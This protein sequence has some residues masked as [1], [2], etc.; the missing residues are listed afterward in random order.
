MFMQDDFYQAE[1]DVVAMVMTQLYL[2]AGHKTWGDS[3][4]ADAHSE[5]KQLHWRNTFKS[6]HLR[7]L[8]HSQRQMVLESHMFLKEKRDEKMKAR[9]VAGGNKQRGYISKDDVDSTTTVDIQSVLLTCIIDAQ[10][11]RGVAVI[12]VPNAFIQ[13]RIEDE[14][15]MAFIKIRSALVDILL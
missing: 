5:M 13:T 10:E 1:L 4:Y 14:K 15:D 9:T 7:E 11:R 12:D 8:S 6:K 2:K 3:A